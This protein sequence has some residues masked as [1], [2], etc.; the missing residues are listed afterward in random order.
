[1]AEYLLRARLPPGSAWTVASA[2]VAGMDGIPA[3]SEAVA[4][5]DELGIDLTSHLSRGVDS[6]M[7]AA[8]GLVVVMTAAQ[9]DQMLALFP[10][11]AEKVFLLRS[12]DKSAT[13]SDI[14]DPIGGTSELYRRVRDEINAAIPGLLD[15]L[16]GDG[17]T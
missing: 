1:M 6:G 3:S 8:A 12:F 10:G 4:A 11:I 7:V 14:E 13:G 2:G 9:R 5:V 16:A 15:Y 17:R